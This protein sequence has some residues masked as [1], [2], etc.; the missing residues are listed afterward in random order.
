MAPLGHIIL[1]PSQLIFVLTLS[2]CLLSG[3]VVFDLTRP[4]LE[5][6]MYHTRG[7]RANSLHKIDLVP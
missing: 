5:S 3:E 4:G 1:I 7:D 2:G 6:I